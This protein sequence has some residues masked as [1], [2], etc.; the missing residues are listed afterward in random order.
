M[1]HAHAHGVKSSATSGSSADAPP[2]SFYQYNGAAPGA[3]LAFDDVGD[4]SGGLTGIPWDLA[5][6]LPI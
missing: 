3:K 5:T 2:L 6:G 1:T 4:S